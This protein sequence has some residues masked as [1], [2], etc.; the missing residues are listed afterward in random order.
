MADFLCSLGFVSAFFAACDAPAPLATGYV[1]GEY[2]QL[3]PLTVVR[4]DSL[5]VARGDRI[6]AGQVLALVEDQDARIA[7]ASAEA[8][9]HK[10][11]SDLANLLEGSRAPEIA[12]IEAAVASARANAD[13]TAKEAERQEQLV[14]QNVSSQATLDAARAAADMAAAAVLEVQAKLEVAALPARPHQIEAAKAA[15]EVAR[16][17]KTLAE[18]QL[19]QRSLTAVAPGVVTDILRRAGEV[20]G[21][22][23]PVLNYLPDGAV[24]LRLYVPEPDLASVSVG[25]RL[26]VSCDGCGPMAAVVTYVSDHAEF[27]PPVIYSNEARQKLVYLVEARPA[28]GAALKPGQIVEVQAAP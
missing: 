16:T 6:A 14:R 8:A 7:L 12:A 1:E 24:K 17:T 19:A 11:E 25:G 27:T 15:V 5:T 20:A 28:E 18:W 9:L 21:P 13:R 3:A 23:A 4:V 2:V 26:V 10:A 22:S